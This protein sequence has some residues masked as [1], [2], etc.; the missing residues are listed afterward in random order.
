VRHPILV[1][2]A[3]PLVL[4]WSWWREFDTRE[5]VEHCLLAIGVVAVLCIL[6]W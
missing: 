6:L 1:Y 5:K 4:A 3:Y 2:V